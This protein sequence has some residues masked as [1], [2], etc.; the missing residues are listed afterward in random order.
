M[1]RVRR[2]VFLRAARPLVVDAGDVSVLDVGS[3]T[4]FYVER[5]REL[6]V[7][8]V[9]A[10]DLTDVAVEGLRA[11]FPS[12]ECRQLDLTA[13]LP[14][15]F[16]GRFDVV[17]GMDMLFHIVDDA[18]YR[19]ALGN[20]ARIVRPGGFVV[21]TENFVRGPVQRT[22]HQVSRTQEEIDACLAAEGLKPVSRAPMFVLMNT[23]VN[24]RTELHRRVWELIT[25]FARRGRRGSALAG[26]VLY[27]FELVLVSTL[28]KGPSTEIMVCR[29][30]AEPARV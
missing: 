10:S 11:A 18:A 12:V 28:R 21:L 30:V 13:E 3:G 7:S 15:E 6:G 29:R 22:V 16:E 4:G 23:P 25:A 24:A 2:H 9:T 14:T 26:A 1:Y 19:T 5:W 17:S 8:R 27:P 20:L